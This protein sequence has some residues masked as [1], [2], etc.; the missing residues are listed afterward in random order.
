MRRGMVNK[1]EFQGVKQSRG[2]FFPSL[3]PGSLEFV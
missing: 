3:L 1:N 2:G